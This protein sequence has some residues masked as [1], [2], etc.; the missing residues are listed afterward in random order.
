MNIK[1]FLTIFFA[2]SLSIIGKASANPKVDGKWYL[3]L[4]MQGIGIL[5]TVMEFKSTGNNFEAFTR[6]GALN[7]YASINNSPMAG[8]LS[9]FLKNGSLIRIIEGEIVENGSDL[10]LKGKFVSLT[11]TFYFDANI[12]N[13][14]M[15]AALTKKNKTIAGKLNGNHK[16]VT[17]PI[18]DYNTVINNIIDTT[19]KYIY[20]PNIISSDK[21]K[22]FNSYLV[23][24]S[25][26]IQDD[27]EMAFAFFFFAE[28]LPF[29]HYALTRNTNE[30]DEILK[31]SNTD[32][33]SL[34]LYTMKEYDKN[35]CYLKI[36]SFTGSSQEIDS[37]FKIINNKNYSF[38]IIDLRDNPGGGINSGL[39][40]AQ[41]LVNKTLNGG[42]FLTRKWFD[43]NTKIPKP[44]EYKNY[45]T[46]SEANH[47]LLLKNLHQYEGV[48]ITA[49][50]VENSFKGK[51]Y[52]LTNE[53][54]G[55]TC[56]PIVFG[57]KQNKYATI[58]GQKTAGAMLT[59]EKFDAGD[60]FIITVPT[61]DFYTSEGFRI[62]GIGVTPNIEVKSN[63]SLNYVIEQIKTLK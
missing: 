40:T 2:I 36:S 41:Y 59:S 26:F 57:L 52:I 54:T 16:D 42:I 3:E 50:P 37:L 19:S 10:I 11:G 5:R 46:I 9:N 53:N 58:V 27:V 30:S 18:A 6:Q 49:N 15:S 17:L 60:G 45:P 48:T 23:S 24:S 63:E 22:K 35:I 43:N 12:I 62:D 34:D 38:L 29:S 20:D 13:D 33:G 55:S 56:E 44:D 21:L 7:D 31:A 28:E 4:N 25:K 47:E 61:A 51:V 32:P 39:R 14:S 1:L 8:M